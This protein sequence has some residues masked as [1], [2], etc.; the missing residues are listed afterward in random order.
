LITANLDGKRVFVTGGTSGIG[1]ACVRTFASMGAVV[2]ANHLP[3]DTQ[4]T[5]VISAL[6]RDGY[7]VSGIAGSVA[8]PEEALKCVEH[9]IHRLDGLDYLI[10]NAG[11]PGTT[12]PIPPEDLDK[13]TEEFW[14]LILST[15]LLGSFRTAKAAA[16]ALRSSGGAIVNIASIA[17]LGTQGS[18]IAYA[19]SKAGVVNLT[20]SLARA[21]APNV[22]VNAVAPGQTATP[23]TEG[24]SDQRKQIAIDKSVLKKRSQP[25][26]IAEAVLFLCAGASMMTG[27][28]IVVDGGM[29]L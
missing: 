27:Q 4:A 2:V 29:T 22:R 24:W 9:A 1:L 13:M 6:S 7:A 17:G 5:S 8:E 19:A 20:R 23:W 14:H 11:T 15:N 12:E 28:T 21:L 26:D 18:S 3:D 16:S 10:N 25:E